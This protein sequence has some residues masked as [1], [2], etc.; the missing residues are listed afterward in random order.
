MDIIKQEKLPYNFIECENEFKGVKSKIKLY[1]TKDNYSFSIS[2]NNFFNGKRCSKCSNVYRYS[3]SE[4]IEQVFNRIIK[5][6]LN[7]QFVELNGIYHG[8]DSK[9]K[10]HCNTCGYEWDVSFAKFLYKKTNCP[11]C[12]KNPRYSSQ[13]RIQQINNIINKENLNYV[14]MGYKGEFN[15]SKTQLRLYCNIHKTEWNPK[16]NDFVNG[17]KRCPFCYR[18]SKGEEII[19]KYLD[20]LNVKYIREY[21]FDDCKYKYKL[22]FD[23]YIPKNNICIEYDGIQHFQPTKFGGVS[24]EDAKEKYEEGKIKDNI[25]NNY[26]KKNNIKLL[27]IK[28]TYSEKEIKNMLITNL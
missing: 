21:A 28:Y 19:S 16:I 6:N 20:E 12:N 7:Y 9:F 15:H 11:K 26:C 18:K 27:R 10:L 25:K 24:I 1:C 23:F 17:N 13:D 5:E 2:F 3:E 4:R 22:H 8:R 14:F